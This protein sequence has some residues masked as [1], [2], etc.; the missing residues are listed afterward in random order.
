MR[1]HSLHLENRIPDH[2]DT[3][4]AGPSEQG[5]ATLEDAPRPPVDVR[6]RLQMKSP[7]HFS[8]GF[9]RLQDTPSIN[10]GQIRC[11][12]GPSVHKTACGGLFRNDS[13]RDNDT[14]AQSQPQARRAAGRDPRGGETPMTQ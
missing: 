3:F 8:F 9:A 10:D 14:S 5:Q 2:L 1:S 4:L 12:A 11:Q 6:Q 13:V 7:A